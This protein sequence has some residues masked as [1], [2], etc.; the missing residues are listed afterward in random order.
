MT[1]Y[2]QGKVY[3]IVCNTTGLTY[4]GSTCEPTIARR[5]AGHVSAWKLWKK[6]HLKKVTTSYKVLENENYEIV[7][8]ELAPC[9]SK[10]EL[11]QRERYYIESNECVN[12]NIPTRTD[13]KYRRDNIDTIN[14]YR[15]NNKERFSEQRAGH[16]LINKER[17]SEQRA[18]YYVNNRE[19]KIEYQLEYTL[20]NKDKRSESNAVYREKNKDKIALYRDN[21]KDKFAEY[22]L[23]NK[24]K[25]TIRNAKY[26]LKQKE[27]KASAQQ[28]EVLNNEYV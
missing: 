12:K 9:N 5:L 14:E 11:H 3:R 18:E 21:N 26:R 16:Y 13:E 15:L 8:V 19:R 17:I 28:A 23:K 24:D 27:L 22:A 25:R 7:L 2:R 4:Y 20:K 1:D 10:M 6:D